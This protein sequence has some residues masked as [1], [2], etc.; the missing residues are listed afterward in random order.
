MLITTP[1]DPGAD[2]YAALTWLD[3]YHASRGNAAWAAGAQG[4]RETAARRATSWIDATFRA[5]F[6]GSRANG[7][8]QALEWPRSGATDASGLAIGPGEVPVEIMAAEAEAALREL[9]SPGALAP[10][11]V[12]VTTTGGAVKR[13]RKWMDGVGGTETEYTEN[14]SSGPTQPVFPVIEGILAP[15]IGSGRRVPFAMTV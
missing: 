8:G 3:D 11:I 12:P 9:A 7:R 14:V 13:L 10:D 1:G 5:R 2:S 4:D 15:L 6:P